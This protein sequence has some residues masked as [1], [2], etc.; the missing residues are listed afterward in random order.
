M[1]TARVLFDEPGPRGRRRIAISTVITSVIIVAVLALAVVRFGRSGQ[2][3]G[4]KWK[5]FT[6]TGI[7]KFLLI[8]LLN[9]LKVTAVAAVVSFPLGALFALIRLARNRIARW[10]ATLYIEVFRST[11]LLLLIYMFVGAL[12]ALGLNLALFWKLTIPIVLVNTALLAE[13]FRA[14]VRALPR[15]Q[16]EAASAIGLTYWQSMRLVILPQAIRIIV[17][18]LVTQLVSLLKDST[19]GY[20]A[21]YAELL[22]TAKLLTSFYSNFIQ[23]YLV[24]AV[25]F[26]LINLGLSWVARQLDRRLGRGR[27]APRAQTA[28]GENQREEEILEST[29]MRTGMR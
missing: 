7:P 27:G 9:T 29:T 13:V 14:G 22:N 19:L 18:A 8:G 25:I 11:P 5:P 3:A 21:S 10:L 16:G 1:S 2:L 28:A 6:E 15:G 26:V 23:S 12:P 24:V 17:P 20:A 4:A